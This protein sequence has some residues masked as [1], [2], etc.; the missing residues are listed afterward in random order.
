MEIATKLARIQKFVHQAALMQQ[1]KKFYI[2][3][4][5]FILLMGLL[6]CSKLNRFGMNAIGVNITPIQQLMPQ[7]GRNTGDNSSHSQEVEEKTVY[8][9]GKVERQVQLVQRQAYQ[10]NDSTGKI[11]AITNQTGLQKGDEVVIKGKVRYE[12]IFLAGKDYGEVYL[13]EN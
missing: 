12:S 8:I 5:T 4:L 3:G 7:P 13:E 11:W 9:Q 6:S 2:R 1:A 10:I